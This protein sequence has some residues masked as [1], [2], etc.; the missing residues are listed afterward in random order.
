MRSRYLIP[1]IS[2]SLLS[3]QMLHAAPDVTISEV[4][5]LAQESI[6]YWH[7]RSVIWT[8]ILGYVYSN[9]SSMRTIYTTP[10]PPASLISPV[11]GADAATVGSLKPTF[12]WTTVDVARS[13][14]IQIAKDAAFTNVV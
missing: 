1:T 4:S 13:Y 14:K 11:D 12:N 9:W 7:V 3:L 2:L 10:L 6:Y 8:S 5:G